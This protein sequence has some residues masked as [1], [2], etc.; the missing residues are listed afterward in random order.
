MEDYIKLPHPSRVLSCIEKWRKLDLRKK[1]DLQ[2]DKALISFLNLLGSFSVSKTYKNSSKLYRLRK[3]EYLIKDTSECWEP[4]AKDAKMGRCNVKGKPVLYV[5]EKLKTPFEEL[6][7]KPDE[8][9]YIIK[10]EQM[11]HLNLT[12]VVPEDFIETQIDGEPLYDK[13]GMLS[14][15]I[16]REFVRSEFLKPVG[17]GTEYLHRISA[18]MCRVWFDDE[19]S[20]GWIYPSVPSPNDLNIAIKPESAHK[21]LRI[22]DIRIVKMVNKKK[23]INSGRIPESSRPWFNMMKMI[24]ETIFKGSITGNQISWLPSHDLGGDS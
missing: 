19:N 12:R 9:V 3:F 18:S 10:Y 15:Q 7:I 23:I 16:L 5:S 17:K 13:D 8:H 20:E 21:K 24:V 11:E 22:K 6:L 4:P 1:S 2:I 14:Y